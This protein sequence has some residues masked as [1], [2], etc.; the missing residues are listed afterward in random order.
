MVKNHR[1]FPEARILNEKEVKELLS[2]YKIKKEHLPKILEKDPLVKVL[3]AKKGDVIEIK[4]K[5]LI[6]GEST[7]Y[8][9]VI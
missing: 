7:Y 3:G 4:R 8:R 2:K 6:T 9:L 5:S 1:L